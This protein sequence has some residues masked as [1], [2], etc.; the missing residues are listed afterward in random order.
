MSSTTTGPRKTY[1][2]AADYSAKQYYIVWLDNQTATLADDADQSGEALMGVM[3][4]K[5]SG[6]IGASV[7]VQMPWGGGSG[8]VIAG[9]TITIGQELTTDG[10]GKAIATTTSDDHV[11]GVAMR[12]AVVG[13]ILEY[14]PC[15]NIVD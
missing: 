10:N 5:P 7:D 9:G 1:I 13:D 11:F 14:A 15:F 6:D 2:T 4:S 3:Q 8:L 12:G